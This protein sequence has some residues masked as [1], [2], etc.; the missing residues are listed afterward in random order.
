MI[1]F[2][3]QRILG[4]MNSYFLLIF[5]LLIVVSCQNQKT[6][7]MDKIVEENT[8]SNID[9]KSKENELKESKLVDSFSDDKKIGSPRK[10][11]IEISQLEGDKDNFVVIKFY[12][13]DK[14]NEWKLNQT[15]ELIKY[16]GLPLDPQIK[17]FNNDGF[18]DLTYISGVAARGANE[19]GNL[20]IYDKKKDELIF[21]KN[22]GDYPN[23]LYNKELD[24]ITALSVYGGYATDFLRIDGDVL[25][26]FAFVETFDNERKIY[27]VD[28]NGKEKLL[29]QDKIKMEDIYV[30]YK[31]FDPPE[32]SY[33]S[34]D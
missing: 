10:N 1:K 7:T 29:R 32:P 5:L 34:E 15:L 24:C 30:R 3:P 23:L 12:S 19:I 6:I 26:K 16:G 28:K 20:L 11:K 33:E 14:Y 18:K 31:N 21:I 22:S 8:N 27:A 13:L 2:V 17:D 4:F 9:S 25:K